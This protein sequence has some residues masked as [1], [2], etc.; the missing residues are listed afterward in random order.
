MTLI[1]HKSACRR[2]SSFAPRVEALEDRNLLSQVSLVGSPS[3]T[4]SLTL[5]ETNGVVS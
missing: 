2:R 3:G 1:A 5:T 4:N